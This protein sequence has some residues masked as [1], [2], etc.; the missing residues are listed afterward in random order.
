MLIRPTLMNWE[1]QSMPF[2]D[3]VN[4]SNADYI[5]RQYEQYKRD[6]RSVDTAGRIA[7][8]RS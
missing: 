7:A 3:F 5:E 2:F 6:P 4:R 1:R 8:W